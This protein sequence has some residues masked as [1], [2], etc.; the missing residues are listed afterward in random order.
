LQKAERDAA[1][2][3]DLEGSRQGQADGLEVGTLF[4]VDAGWLIGEPVDLV[5]RAWQSEPQAGPV[6][7]RRFGDA[8]SMELYFLDDTGIAAAPSNSS[9]GD[10]WIEA[11]DGE[12]STGERQ[13]LYH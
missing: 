4:D 6:S 11:R 10:K 7:R 5:E 9:A 8:H 2:D 1:L 3:H 12:Y 13:T